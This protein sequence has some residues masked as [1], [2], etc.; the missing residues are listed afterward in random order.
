MKRIYVHESI[1]PQ[2]R[3]AMV[4]HAQ[5]LKV[6][7]GFDEGVTHGPVQNAM[8]YEIVKGHFAD[9]E[10]E[11]YKVAFGG[12]VYQSNTTANGTVYHYALSGQEDVMSAVQRMIPFLVEKKDQAEIVMGLSQGNCV[13]AK[14]AL[15]LLHGHK[16]KVMG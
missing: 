7:P 6:G 13:Q 4:K 16:R 1:Y 11:N 10:K 12:K 8:Q 2:F 3:D 15:H 5:T 14:A 9:I